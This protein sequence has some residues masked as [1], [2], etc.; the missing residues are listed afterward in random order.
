MCVNHDQWVG[1]SGRM[2]GLGYEHEN[3]CQNERH[4]VNP[5][6]IPKQVRTK[7]ADER[8][9]YVATKQR[10]WLCRG[11]AGETK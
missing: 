6:R 3:E 7:N 5:K 10:A 11:R 8:A 2:Y 4:D 1:A 9:A